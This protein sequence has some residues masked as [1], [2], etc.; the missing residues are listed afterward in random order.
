MCTSRGIPGLCADPGGSRTSILGPPASVI[1][2]GMAASQSLFQG[3]DEAVLV[4][5]RSAIAPSTTE[6]KWGIVS[7]WC[8]NMQKD[9]HICSVGS[10]FSAV[11]LNSRQA[12]GTIWV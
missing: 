12:T 4:T 3:Q 6:Q 9:P 5:I 10:T 11:L 2:L 7:A 8:Q 1:T